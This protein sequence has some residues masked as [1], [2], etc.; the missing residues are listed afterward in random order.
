MRKE[1][2]KCI[3]NLPKTKNLKQKKESSSFAITVCCFV[4]I[5][6]AF[7]FGCKPFDS[8]EQLPEGLVF[9]DFTRGTSHQSITPLWVTC[10]ASSFH[11]SDPRG[12][13]AAL[14]DD[15]STAWQT[16][17]G[18][19]YEAEFHLYF[20]SLMAKSVR[21]ELAQN[22]WFSKPDSIFVRW[23]N[24]PWQSS[25]NQ[26]EISGET[27]LLNLSIRLGKIKYLNYYHLPISVDSNS[28]E[29]IHERKTGFL[30]NSRPS[31]IRSIKFFDNT[32]KKLN[33]SS[34][35]SV[36]FMVKSFQGEALNKF[37][38]ELS[39]F[40]IETPLSL[41]DSIK[42]EFILAFQKPITINVVKI[43]S[44]DPLSK[45]NAS[46]LIFNHASSRKFSEISRVIRHNWGLELHLTRPLRGKNFYLGFNASVGQIGHITFLS[47]NK[48][49]WPVKIQPDDN[50][51]N[52]PDTAAFKKQ[53]LKTDLQK[54]LN[55][56]IF[57]NQRTYIY[58]D[59]IKKCFG[60]NAQPEDTIPIKEKKYEI[61]LVF[62]ENRKFELRET[63]IEEIIAHNSNKR[64]DL[65]QNKFE[66]IWYPE[67]IEKEGIK[68]KIQ[69]K[70]AKESE[71]I[72]LL[73]ATYPNEDFVI[74]RSDIIQFNK[75]G[76]KIPLPTLKAKY[77]HFP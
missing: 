45:L 61:R 30:F 23:N 77:P 38:E 1:A 76:I 67:S 41:P 58:K 57:F 4:V 66:G 75:L 70:K 47:D 59:S 3:I 65:H 73:T 32:G 44:T 20:D 53:I 26:L 42:N 15:T 40:H 36:G 71:S 21:I 54:L 28:C 11:P 55:N 49:Y 2:E 51:I 43:F 48:S 74:V 37:T 8:D 22:I 13:A 62:L 5:K 50:P 60:R 19:G 25:E 10:S 56:M 33:I 34:P 6:L 35:V 72:Q 9:E 68:L 14:D 64:V 69:Y 27:P 24:D 12:F 17:A 31:G 29:A 63:E 46:A 39:D 16:L 7:F 52:P 18:C